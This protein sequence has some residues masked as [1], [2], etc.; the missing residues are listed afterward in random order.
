LRCL[1]QRDRDALRAQR[2]ERTR[3]IFTSAVNLCWFLFKWTAALAVVC[4]VVAAWYF[5][6]TLDGEIRDH[7]RSTLV[8]HFDQLDVRLQEARRV[9]G[10]GILIRGLSLSERDA[11]GPLAEIAFFDEIFLSCRTDLEGLIEGKLDPQRLTIRRPTLRATRRPD[12]SWSVSQLLPL[13]DFGESTAVTEIEN[14]TIVVFD[15]LKN[16]S[17]TFTLRDINLVIRPG[18][19]TDEAAPS[20]HFEGSLSGDFLGRVELRGWYDDRSGRW[21][22]GGRVDELSVS[23]ELPD[24]LPGE[25]GNWLRPV[26]PF[27][28][29]VVLNFRVDSD[30]QRERPLHFDVRG[31]LS[32]GRIDDERLPYP[33]TDVNGSIRLNQNGVEIEDVSARSGRTTLWLHGR[34]MGYGEGSHLSLQGN[35]RRL[36]LDQQ[37]VEAMPEKWQRIWNKY[38]P[39]GE[40]DATVKL[41]HDGHRWHP[42]L[43]VDCTNVSFTHYRFPYRV[44]H[45]RGRITLKDNLMNIALDAAAGSRP[46]RIDAEV[47]NPGPDAV[48]YLVA[49]TK[50]LPLDER[51]FSALAEPT[52]SIVKSFS[53]QGTINGFLRVSRDRPDTPWENRTVIDLNQIAI[54]Y[55]K[56]P[57]PLRN[58]RGR[59]TGVNR[60]WKY[61]ELVGTNDTGYVTASGQSVPA[62]A[63]SRTTFQ[64]SGAGV[65]LDEE[66]RM[67]LSPEMQALWARIK[68]RGRVGLTTWLTYDSHSR[69]LDLTVRTD[70]GEDGIVIEPD[71]F[72]YRMENLRG[73]ITFRRGRADFS[74]LTAT[75]GRT[76]L[77]S[78]GFCTFQPNGSWLCQLSNLTV[79][80]LHVDRDLL[81]AVPLRLRRNLAALNFSGPLNVVGSMRFSR[82]AG[83]GVA[84]RTDWDMQLDT[85][86]GRIDCGVML[87]QISGGA[88]FVGGFDGRQFQSRGWLDVDS[89]LYKGFQFTEVRG[90][91]WLREDRIL[92]GAP[93]DPQPAGQPPRRIT[94]RLYDGTLVGDCQIMPGDTTR[95]VMDA[96]LVDADLQ[97]F[98]TEAMKGSANV[99]GKVAGNLH[100]QGTNRGIHTLRGNGNVSVR[101]GDVY[102]LPLVVSLLKFLSV[103]SD[104][105]NRFDNSDA[106]FRIEGN[107]V[108]LDQINFYGD[109][110]SLLGKGEMD[111]DRNIRMVF[112][113][114]VGRGRLEV[115]ILKPV[116]GMA[117]KQLMLIYVHGTLDNP[118]TTR[119]ALPGVRRAVQGLE[120]ELTQPPEEKSMFRKTRDWFDT[121]LP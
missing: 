24:A 35:G 48:G 61:E 94:A 26:K 85:F 69:K 47:L 118:Q 22:V 3:A 121:V 67:A 103:K 11:G 104:D 27:R 71:F 112:H 82:D 73:Q 54:D 55:E 92:L 80:H 114:I 98:A 49:Q 86:Q 119:E 51:F 117:S 68:P 66:L 17:S 44:E 20:H 63:G 36:V 46:V 10:Q 28:G 96:Q 115:P 102:Q 120:A 113:A 6:D 76:Q 14:A 9:E 32:R 99:R 57:Y 116:L 75:H 107:H 109:A 31:R 72:P 13:P 100:L 41:E 40:V 111:F 56:F 108:L 4:G 18:E 25:I 90:P 29:H 53:P 70:L 37:M 91:I 83:Q 45:G 42:E 39:A 93:A 7:V 33:L 110:V 64:I 19:R 50:S 58:V 43:T 101:N 12:G 59:L 8:S 1:A 2:C 77:A 81:F 88:R 5:R 21:G 38:L 87:D 79:D 84:V 74:N 65:P 106:R 34:Q 95:F 15:P 16:P 78:N 60:H 30:P 97:R 105:G 23:P 89:L 52:R 62:V